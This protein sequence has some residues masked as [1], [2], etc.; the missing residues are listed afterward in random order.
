MRVKRRVM[1]C[2]CVA[3]ALLCGAAAAVEVDGIA[4]RVGEDAILRSDVV[5]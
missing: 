1:K 5:A 2:A 4:A 3:A